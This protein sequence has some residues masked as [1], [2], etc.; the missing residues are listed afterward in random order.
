M[1]S[2]KL[3]AEFLRVAATFESYSDV[4]HSPAFSKRSVLKRNGT[5][6]FMV[7]Q[8]RFVAKLPSGRVKELVEAGC[9]T[10]FEPRNGRV[11]KEWLSVTSKTFDI[12]SLAK[13]A[14]HFASSAR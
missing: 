14:Y 13:E 10:R 3:D 4:Q 1:L 6:F 9:G 7:S 11:M 5:I 8:G 12:C 2:S